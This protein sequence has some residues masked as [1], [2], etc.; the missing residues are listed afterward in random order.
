MKIKIKSKEHF[1]ETL[2]RKGFT[3]RQ[4]GRV[5]NISCPMVIQIVNG[6]RSPSPATAKR[7]TEALGVSFDDVFVIDKSNIK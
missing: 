1:L 3:K 2:I 6:E 5:A 4:L 7:I